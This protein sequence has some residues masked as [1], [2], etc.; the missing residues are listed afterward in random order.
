[1]ALKALVT[2]DELKALPGELQAFYVEH[3]EFHRLDVQAVNGWALEDISGLQSTLSKLKQSNAELK[4]KAAPA[5]GFDFE[6]AKAA[7]ERVKALEGT[8]GKAKEQ[9][10]A[11]RKNMQEAFDKERSK[12]TESYNSLEQQHQRSLVEAAASAAL[13][14]HKGDPDLLMP[15][16]VQSVRA[17]RGDDG[18]YA[19]RV[20]D[21]DG[22][23][24]L[25]KQSGKHAL[26]MDVEEYVGTVLKTRFPA[27]FEGVGATGS[28]AG[29]GVR[30]GSGAGRFSISAEV[31]RTDP[32]A[33]QRVRDEAVKAGQTVTIVE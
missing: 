13:G 9:I 26:P 1:M 14:K 22:R 6:A 10:E 33:Y 30:S 16:I 31:A 7:M 11:I 28:G 19:Q 18:K 17:V 2:G 5:D 12:W 32:R 27:A 25:S 29:G 4:A 21:A 3:G 15:H 20:F 24:A 23:E 8:E